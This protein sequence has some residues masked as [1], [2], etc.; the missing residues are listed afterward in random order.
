MSNLD[1]DISF[2]YDTKNNDDSENKWKIYLF[3][4]FKGILKE[5]LEEMIEK[6]EY[7]LFFIGLRYEYGYYVQRDIN[8]ALSFYKKGAKAN[9]TDY[10]SMARLYDIYATKDKKFN[11]INDKNLEIIYLLK[12]FAYLPMS[13]LNSNPKKNRC[14]LNIKYSALSFITYNGSELEKIFSYIDYLTN[15]GKY[16]DILSINDS[17][18]IKGFIDGYINYSLNGDENS[19]NLLIA[20]SLEGNLEANCRLISIYFKILYSFEIND[21]NKV[22]LIKKEIFNQ[23][24]I[25]EKAKYYKAYGQYGL[26]L[27]NNMRMFDKTLNIF[28]QG[29]EN[30]MYE[31]SI[32]YFHAFTKSENQSIYDLNRFNSQQFI[33]IFKTLIDTSALDRHM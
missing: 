33:D 24:Q 11:I 18:L 19:L 17:N 31:C 23:F 15:S 13:Y 6:S 16:K 9:S 8:K 32:Y 30:N 3:E 29:Y 1:F 5:R 4:N 2:E 14:P 22:E 26:F 25:L 20:L 27:Y 10:L 28:K 7:K 12:S 21:E